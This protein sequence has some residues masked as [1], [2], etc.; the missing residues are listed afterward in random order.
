MRQPIRALLAATVA[1]TAIVI[2]AAASSS[3]ATPPAASPPTTSERTPPTPGI[4]TCVIQHPDCNDMGFGSG[5]SEPGSSGST[6]G[7]APPT[8][9]PVPTCG[10]ETIDSM[11]GPDG[12][13]ATLPCIRGPDRKPQPLIVE[14][15][16]GMANVRPISFTSATVEPDDRTVD[17]QFWSGV[18]PCSVLDHV[19]VAYGTDGVTITLFD[20]SDPNAGMVACPDI[21]VLKQVTVPLDQAA[22]G[23][24]IVDGVT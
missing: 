14:P 5:G 22:T 15:R 3:A 13:V 6:D 11:S 23:R 21:A 17:V 9:A 24:R 10:P 19:D 1:V 20:G 18:E 8:I 4:A 2:A 7:T 16:S 12:T